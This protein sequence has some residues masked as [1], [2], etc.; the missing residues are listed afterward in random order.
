MTEGT[1][2][3]ILL[4][5]PD[6]LGES[7]SLQ[8]NTEESNFE[9]VLKKDSEFISK[10]KGVSEETTTGVNRLYH[11]FNDGKL[12]FPAVNVN[13]YVIFIERDHNPFEIKYPVKILEKTKGIGY[14]EGH[15]FYK[16]EILNEIE[17]DSSNKEKKR[18]V[19]DFQ[20]E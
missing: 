11:L 16:I 9:V 4:L 17:I 20:L 6:L 2:N 8:L 10:I 1:P 14:Y 7:L 19:I 12:P 18:W 5:A 3:Q 13:D 15:Y